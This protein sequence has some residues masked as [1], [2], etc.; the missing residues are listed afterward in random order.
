MSYKRLPRASSSSSS[1]LVWLGIAILI[2]FGL[3][4]MQK[5]RRCAKKTDTTDTNDISTS[6][7][8]STPST[9]STPSKTSH[10][11]EEKS[12]ENYMNEGAVYQYT[13]QNGKC[14]M[15]YRSV[16]DG[17]LDLPAGRDRCPGCGF[18]SRYDAP[19]F[20]FYCPHN[21]RQYGVALCDQGKI[22]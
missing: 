13:G 15:N 22:M 12:H 16:N 4:L 20:E 3:V 14:A 18:L 7:T 10:D 17:N 11:E 1:F 21:A 19:E 9:P 6:S 2:A 8:T 5:S